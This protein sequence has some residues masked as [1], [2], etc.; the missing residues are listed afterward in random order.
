MPFID[1]LTGGPE[2]RRVLGHAD[3]LALRCAMATRGVVGG[4]LVSSLVLPAILQANVQHLDR[5]PATTRRHLALDG[6]FP[7][8]ERR[9]TNISGVASSLGV[10]RET[11]RMKLEVMVAAGLVERSEAGVIVPSRVLT[12]DLFLPVVPRLL[13][14]A[15]EFVAGLAD[16]GCAGLRRG[17]RLADPVWPV[18]GAVLRLT[19]AHALRGVARLR[20]LSP[21]RPLMSSFVLLAVRHEC[22]LP[23]DL[24][25]A[26]VAPV[27]GA[28]IARTYDV[29]LETVRRQLHRLVEAGLLARTEAGYHPVGH[30]RHATP[31]GIGGVVADT[32]KLVRRLRHCGAVTPAPDSVSDIAGRAA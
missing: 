28:H 1:A 32:R 23:A 21:D 27:S 10:P 13:D 18:A 3:G 31:A 30:A 24:R 16:D 14:A 2:A 29:P 4:D 22:R 26:P 15:A 17:E 19:T 20:S 6:G 7:D 12:S 5:D 8:A 25:S 11:V 9:P